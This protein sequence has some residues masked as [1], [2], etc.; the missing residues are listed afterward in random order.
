MS[1][2]DYEVKQ[3]LCCLSETSW[4][5]LFE[6]VYMYA[7]KHFTTILSEYNC[8]EHMLKTFRDMWENETLKDIIMFCV[9]K[10]VDDNTYLKH[11]DS[12]TDSNESL[13][14]S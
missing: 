10:Q 13:G 4:L 6:N 5:K 7:L 11:R 8:P 1:L 3:C 12:S 9:S 2:L 14:S